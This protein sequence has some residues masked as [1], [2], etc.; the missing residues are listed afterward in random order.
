MFAVVCKCVFVVQVECEP[1]TAQAVFP[2]SIER[3]VAVKKDGPR[4]EQYTR[5]LSLCICER[6]CKVM[7]VQ[8]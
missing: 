5:T 8:N 7:H 6:V 4:S 1:F 2:F 3:S